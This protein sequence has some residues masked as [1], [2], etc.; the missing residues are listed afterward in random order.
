MR[1]KIGLFA[2]SLRITSGID[3]GY[4]RR[5]SNEFARRD[6]A[7]LERAFQTRRR[8]PFRRGVGHGQAFDDERLIASMRVKERRAFFDSS[9]SCRVRDVTGGPRS[10]L[11]TKQRREGCGQS[12]LNFVGSG[13]RRDAGRA[14]LCAGRNYTANF[15]RKSR[16]KEKERWEPPRAARGGKKARG[17]V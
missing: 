11:Q 3:G 17:A 2:I 8:V 15:R 5:S 6:A 1:G 4:R 12:E 13:S 14:W 9:G 10:G 16:I 7:L